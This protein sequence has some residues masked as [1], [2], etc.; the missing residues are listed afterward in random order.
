MPIVEI[1]HFDTAPQE[2]QDLSTHGGDED[3]IVITRDENNSVYYLLEGGG[4]MSIDHWVMYE[5]NGEQVWIGA[6]A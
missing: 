5:H 6:H 4:F 3:Y 2:L 1:W